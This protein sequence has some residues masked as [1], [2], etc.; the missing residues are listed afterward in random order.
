MMTYLLVLNMTYERYV[1]SAGGLERP[2]FHNYMCVLMH[3][4][5]TAIQ[6]AS[7]TVLTYIH[8]Y[9]NFCLVRLL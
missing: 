5:F 7:L 4:Y 6:C 8:V 3:R 2:T 9:G 1:T